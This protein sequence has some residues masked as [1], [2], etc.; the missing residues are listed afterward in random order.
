[1]RH[2]SRH[3]SRNASRHAYVKPLLMLLLLAIL[4]GA[5]AARSAAAPAPLDAAA[6]AG[7]AATHIGA[8]S[9]KPGFAAWQDGSPRIES[10]GPGTHGWLATVVGPKG[11]PLGYLVLYAAPDGA[12]RLGEYGLGAKP[13]FDVA[14]LRGALYRS[15][16]IPSA[17]SGGYRAIKHY[18]HP[19]LAAWEVRLAKET[20]WLDAKTA[21]L[22]PVRSET[23]WQAAA[24]AIPAVSAGSAAAKAGHLRLMSAAETRDPYERLSWLLGDPPLSP[25]PDKLTARIEAKSPLVYVVEPLGD[26]MLYALSV[27]GYHSWQGGRL[28]LALNMNGTRFIP[29]ESLV[30]SADGLFYP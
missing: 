8:L 22:L 15:G 18:D 26:R 3:A 17:S 7:C 12:C 24:A 28:D 30:K 19:F 29:L 9:G 23:D 25:Q 6:I 10:L 13:L 27:V 5:V 2:T 14:T 11:A 21:E 1:M 20:I 16:Y 4:S